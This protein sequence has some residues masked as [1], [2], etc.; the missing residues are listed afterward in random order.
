MYKYSSRLLP[1]V[2]NNFF[3]FSRLADV[4]GYNTRNAS[5]QH[6]HVS[7]WRTT[8]GQKTLSYCGARIWNY[9]L[10]NIDPDCVIGTYK[11]LIKRLFLNSKNELFTWFSDT[12]RC[13][14][15]NDNYVSCTY[16]Y[17]FVCMR[18]YIYIYIH[19]WGMHVYAYTVQSSSILHWWYLF[20]YQFIYFVLHSKNNLSGIIDIGVHKLRLQAPFARFYMVISW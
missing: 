13:L 4:H 3:T 17:P 15:I 16:V 10:D 11:K 1:D 5:T 8:R 6:L 18:T 19:V 7:V 9:I 20:I 12:F 2:F 14:C